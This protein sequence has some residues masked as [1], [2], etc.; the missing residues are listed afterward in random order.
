MPLELARNRACHSEKIDTDGGTYYHARRLG[1]SWP[2]L[3]RTKDDRWFGDE[4]SRNYFLR[5]PG[6]VMWT[7]DGR[8]IPDERATYSTKKHT[9]CWHEITA[10][11]AVE[12]WEKRC[13]D[14]PMP[15]ELRRD[16]MAQLRQRAGI[17]ARNT[18]AENLPSL[19]DATASPAAATPETPQPI[20]LGGPDDPVFLWGKEK[21]P[22][23]PAQYRVIK[24]LVD[25][26]AKGKRLSKDVLCGATKDE[27]G[28]TVE[29]PVGA[30]ERLMKRDNDW[31]DVIDMAKTP[32]RGYGLKDKPPTPTQGNRVSHPGRNRF[33]APGF[34]P[35]PLVFAHDP[36]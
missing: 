4:Y 19:P 32:G 16:W 33:G 18:P 31:R 24:A 7:E 14:E 30:L 26:R 5:R 36:A 3:L 1:G 34:S 20:V 27:D 23:P 12:W 35:F 6:Q 25:A 22:L 10:E 13:P 17:D 8:W 2:R 9:C 29:D 21:D 28:N 15:P 11:T